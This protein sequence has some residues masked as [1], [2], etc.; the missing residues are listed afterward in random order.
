MVE[1][2]V[3]TMIAMIYKGDE[4]HDLFPK[5]LKSGHINENTKSHPFLLL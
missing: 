4:E 3:L 5:I 2:R 1:K